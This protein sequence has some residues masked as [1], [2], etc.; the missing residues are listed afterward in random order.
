MDN[1]DL[2]KT[3]GNVYLQDNHCRKDL[4]H[5]KR[6][7]IF[8]IWTKKH[9][10]VQVPTQK[11]LQKKSPKWTKTQMWDRHPK[12]PFDTF[13]VPIGTNAGPGARALRLR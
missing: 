1:Q 10:K 7:L 4:N 13:G 2:I 3:F 5:Q 9:V 6:S 12:R 11:K 8:R